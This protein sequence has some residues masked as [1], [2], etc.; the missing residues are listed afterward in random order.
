MRPGV[1][2]LVVV[3][4][5]GLLLLGGLAPISDG[6]STTSRSSSLDHDVALVAAERSPRTVITVRAR[7]FR[8]PVRPALLGLNHRFV[9]NGYG[10]WDA[11]RDR[12]QPKVVRQLRRGG[13]RA[14]RFPGGTISNLYRWRA[15]I[16]DRHG[17]QVAGRRFRGGYRALDTRLAYGIDEHMRLAERVGARTVL[18]AQTITET[19][20]NLANWV[21]YMNVRAGT[22]ANPNGGVDWAEVRARNGHPRPYHV[23]HWELGN[24]YRLLGQRYWM[25][26]RD[27]LAIRQYAF[28][29]QR[30]V[31]GERLGKNCMHRKVGVRSNGRRHQTFE[32]LYPPTVRP[33]VTVSVNGHEWR[34]VSSLRSVGPHARAYVVRPVLGEVRFGDGRHGA[35]P[36]RRAVVRASYRSVHEGAFAFARAMKAVDPD[37]EVCLSWGKTQ[38]LNVVKRRSFDC[39]TVHRYVFFPRLGA[40]NWN[41]ALEGHDLHMLR[42]PHEAEALRDIRARLPR[43]IPVPLTEFGSLFGDSKTYPRWAVSMTHATFVASELLMWLKM[44]VPWATGG[45]PLMQGHRGVV[46]PA[47]HFTLTPELAARRALAPM[48]HAK[49]RLVTAKV[50]DNPRRDPRVAVGSYP[51]L[52]VAASRAGNR[53]FV[54]V[55][56]RLPLDG[57]RVRA[58]IRLRGFRAGGVA[59]VRRVVGD[60]FRDWNPPGKPLTVRVRTYKVD[61]QQRGLTIRFPAHSV[62]LLS[63]RRR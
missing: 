24:E 1:G 47:P 59:T 57:E 42:L 10:S 40:E 53:V 45:G 3:A 21:E 35:V 46:G 7:S 22:R 11:A 63:M 20:L 38:F 13:V 4:A 32:M 23:R 34:Q 55:V 51:A 31:T 52:E 12:P 58:A 36:P 29:G 17:C 19:P 60:S 39:F 14:V 49:G 61:T 44:Q 33:S 27:R 50:S 62:T 30:R 2:R 43:R 9:R 26:K 25:S 54:A 8:G 16:G 56:N 41:T 48:F 37:I 5:C 28:G 15:A 18:M 6:R